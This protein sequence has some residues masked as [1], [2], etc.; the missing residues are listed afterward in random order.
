MKLGIAY[1]LFD[2]IEL[3]EDSI[4]GIRNAA[5]YIV[6]IYQNQSNY[7]EENSSEVIEKL[8]KLHKEK[9]IDDVFLYT[10]QLK[11][12]AHVNEITKRNIGLQKCLEHG[13]N[14]FSSMD[15]DEIYMQDEYEH[16]LN[17]FWSSEYD[18]CACKMLT[19]Y[20]TNEYV[21]DP[22]E[23]Y[24]VSLFYKVNE[25]S[26]FEFTN[27]PVLVDPTRRMSS[28]N[29]WAIPR[30]F[31]QM[32][33]FS[34]VRNNIRQKLMNSSA[35]V[36]FKPDQLEFVIDYFNNWDYSKPAKMLG[37]DITDYKTRK[38]DYWTK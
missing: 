12:S 1:N 31:L 29:V 9:L 15:V 24:Y 22:P 11:V 5:D 2:G 4:R 10:P 38:V 30:D 26:K 6:V 13:C 36:N 37:M 32:H 34:Y 21:L 3:F 27:F 19:Y 33:H 8:R 28:K 7:G 14:V 20:K 25:N 23:D 35:R 16:I 18:A 17:K